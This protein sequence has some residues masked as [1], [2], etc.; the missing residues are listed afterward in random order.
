MPA[1]DFA[2]QA[3]QVLCSPSAVLVR[4]EFARVGAPSESKA[5][6][7]VATEACQLWPVIDNSGLLDH[8]K[9]LLILKFA[10]F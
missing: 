10:R 3:V 9:P 2:S 1:T 8:F 4:E 6:H 5:V 7:Q